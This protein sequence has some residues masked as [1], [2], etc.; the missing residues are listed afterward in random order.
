MSAPPLCLRVA[1]HKQSFK[2]SNNQT[3]LSEKVKE[4]QNK[5]IECNVTF[6]VLEN[7][8]SYKPESKHCKLCIAE[9]FHIIYSKP[10]NILIKK[11]EVISKCRHRSKSKLAT[12]G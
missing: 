5:N 6:K 1:T 4:I 10:E 12:N 2:T 8:S 11:N 9:K 7:R 3:V